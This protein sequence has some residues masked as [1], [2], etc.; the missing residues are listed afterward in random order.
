MRRSGVKLDRV[1]DSRAIGIRAPGTTPY[2]V[3]ARTMVRE[4]PARSFLGPS[5]MV[6]QS[7]LYNPIFFPYA[8]VLVDFYHI[9]AD[10]TKRYFFPFAAGSL[11]GSI[12][13][14]PLFDTLG[15]RKMI[16]LTY[17]PPGILLAISGVLFNEGVLS[18]TTQ[19]VFRCLIFFF[20]ASAGASSAYLTVSEIFPLEL[21][22]QA[23]SFFFAISQLAGG[24]AAP[25][26]F[27]ALVDHRHHTRAPAVGYHVGPTVMCTGG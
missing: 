6:A 11:A 24:V 13:L 16:L 4:Y 8:L 17:G 5:M 7:F 22:S 25:R 18:V 19:T 1:A 12:L 14:G 21:R 26:R 20:I 23:N 3:I 2:R 27:A 10:Q 15:R 9:A